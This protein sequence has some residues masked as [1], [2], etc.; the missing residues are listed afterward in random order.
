MSHVGKYH[1]WAKGANFVSKLPGD[2]K[3]QKAAVEEATRTL[4]RDLREKKLSEQVI[5]YSDKLFHRAAIEWLVVTDQL[6]QA[7]EHPKF[8]EM[9]DVASR[10]TNRVKI[11]GRKATQA[12]IMRMF[13]NHL[14][15]LKSRLNG[16]VVQG[17]VSLT[18]DAWQAG[19]TDGYFV[20]TAHWIEELTPGK[21]ELNNA[22]IGFTHLNN[23]HNGER[24]GQALF[25]IVR[26]I[27][28]EDKV[29]HITCNNA[30]NNPTMMKEFAAR[31]KTATGRKYKWRKRKINCLTHVINL[32]M[33]ML[34]S[35]Y[36]KSPHFDPK[37]PEA[38]IPTSHDEVGLVRAI[39]V[40]AHIDT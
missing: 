9:I 8:K 30:S 15:T 7:L 5:P 13:K 28:I 12:E 38:H 37:Q 16:P 6:I 10:A 34:I 2:I 23:A 22:L 18:C 29:G 19:N 21:W 27:G 32:A 20:V 24:L 33:Q 36:S 1:N 17:K 40:K 11:P 26:C 3:K 4:D 14:T 35:T 39:V 31:L 25:K